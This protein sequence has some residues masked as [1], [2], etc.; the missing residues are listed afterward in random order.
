[1]VSDLEI[2][3]EFF[4]S[5]SFPRQYQYPKNIL[6]HVSSELKVK[7]TYYFNSHG[8]WDKGSLNTAKC[9]GQTLHLFGWSCLSEIIIQTSLRDKGH[10]STKICILNWCHSIF[11]FHWEI[12]LLFPRC[13]YFVNSVGPLVS[14]SKQ[15]EATY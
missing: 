4:F 13:Y 2:Y 8:K 6:L 15:T 11:P 14:H 1:M 3:L 9:D 10:W 12:E 7:C 5:A